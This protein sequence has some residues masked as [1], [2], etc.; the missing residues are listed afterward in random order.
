MEAKVAVNGVELWYRISGEGEPVAQIHGA[1]FGHFNFDPATPELSKHFK[2]IDYDLR[3]Y[4]QSDRPVQHYDM[5]VWADDLA[6]LMDALEIEDAHVH[7]TSMGGMIA[8]AFAGKYPERTTSVVINCA[9]AKLGVTGRLIFKNW[10]DIARLDRDGP[11]S[12]LLAELIT[13]QALSKRFL[14]E[15]DAAELTDLIQQILRDSNRIEVFTA[16]CQA[17]CDMDL[18]SWLPKITSPALV[19][20][21]D[22]DLM[23]PWDQGPGGAGQEAIFQG[24]PGAEKHVVR[25]SNHS[26]IFDGSEEHNRVVIDFFKRHS[27]TI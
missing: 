5:E 11:G 12:R 27:R 6:G 13:W 22:E 18:T 4:G 25:G 19:L 21:G 20:G 9:A 17:M 10:I 8:I 7:G 14:E 16:A 1:G 3:G 23:T 26:T 2:V 15:Q 24:I